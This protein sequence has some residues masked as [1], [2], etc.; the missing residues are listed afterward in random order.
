MYQEVPGGYAIFASKGGADSNPGWLHNL[1]AQ[2]DTAVEVGAE[3]VPVRAREVHGAERDR[4]WTKQKEDY[5]F[6]ADY[7]RKT[8]RDVIPVIVLEQI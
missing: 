1:R 2:P 6:F 4:I 7:E 5:P 8:S 3:T